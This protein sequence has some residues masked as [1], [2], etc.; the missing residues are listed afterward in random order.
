[1]FLLKWYILIQLPECLG[2]GDS[3]GERVRGCG[4]ALSDRPRP[5]A[6]V[7]PCEVEVVR[8]AA[9]AIARPVPSLAPVPAPCAGVLG[10]GEMWA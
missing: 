2:S 10:D 6:Y 7:S 1:M 8:T 9:P 3:G 4:G 5:L